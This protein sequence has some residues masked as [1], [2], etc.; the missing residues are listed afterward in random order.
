MIVKCARDNLGS[1]RMF[2]GVHNVKYTYRSAKEF[3]NKMIEEYGDSDNSVFVWDNPDIKIGNIL[4]LEFALDDGHRY[5]IITQ[6][7]TFLM[8]DEGKTIE[9]LRY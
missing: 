3:D 7:Q 4:V 6:Y 2:D 8:N 9:R 1:W 5:V